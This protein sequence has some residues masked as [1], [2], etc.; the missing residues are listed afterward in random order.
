M[1]LNE[2]IKNTTD[3]LYNEVQ[4]AQEK[5]LI[6]DIIMIYNRCYHTYEDYKNTIIKGNERIEEIKSMGLTFTIHPKHILLDE[7]VYYFIRQLR[8][9]YKG[10]VNA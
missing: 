10:D 9:L 3:V 1:D 8:N 4:K 5:L 7:E 2:F 6:Q